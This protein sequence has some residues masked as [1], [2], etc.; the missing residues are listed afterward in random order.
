MFKLHS[1]FGKTYKP[2]LA[3]IALL[4]LLTSC[5]DEYF[6][7]GINVKSG[8]YY[9]IAGGLLFDDAKILQ[10]YKYRIT[11]KKSSYYSLKQ[12]IPG[13]GGGGELTLW[14]IRGPHEYQPLRASPRNWDT[15][16]P[17]AMKKYGKRVYDWES[18][19]HIDDYFQRLF[20]LRTVRGIEI[21]ATSSSLTEPL[22]FHETRTVGKQTHLSIKNGRYHYGYQFDDTIGFILLKR[23]TEETDKE[24][25]ITRIIFPILI[26]RSGSTYSY[27]H[28]LQQIQ[29]R[30]EQ[31]FLE[32]K[33]NNYYAHIWGKPIEEEGLSLNNIHINRER[34]LSELKPLVLPNYN[35]YMFTADILCNKNCSEKLQNLQP[36]TW[37]QS[38]VE[39]NDFL[40]EAKFFLTL[41]NQEYNPS[42]PVF[43]YSGSS[44]YE[45][46]LFQRI[47]GSEGKY[48]FML[49]HWNSGMVEQDSTPF[50]PGQHNLSWVYPSKYALS[51]SYPEILL[52]YRNSAH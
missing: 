24:R 47:K 30:L 6:L 14:P 9:L 28:T 25:Y 3:I 20:E 2:L 51:Q 49:N 18:Y 52:N 34:Y 17:E 10:K 13:E 11:M 19:E 27:L 8:N 5:S 40:Q 21:S 4:P 15:H 16:I 7:S 38:E 29:Q 31:N 42:I 12:L 39:H 33:I 23:S 44:R 43:D 32:Q 36:L 26:T 22:K 41:N 37:M 1:D 45:L 48:Q 50:E 35:S 46:F